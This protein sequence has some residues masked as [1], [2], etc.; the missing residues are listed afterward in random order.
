MGAIHH[1]LY[2]DT[3][4]HRVPTRLEV[5]SSARFSL[6]SKEK[7]HR[8]QTREHRKRLG[9]FPSVAGTTAQPITNI[10]STKC[11]SPS[12]APLSPLLK[13]QRLQQ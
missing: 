8:S 13:L 7:L 9:L 5:V 2:S 11:Q 12:P 1:S 3:Q 10:S 6:H 4:A